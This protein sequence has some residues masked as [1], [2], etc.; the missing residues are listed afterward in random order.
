VSYKIFNP[1]KLYLSLQEQD[2]VELKTEGLFAGNTP[3]ENAGSS[4]QSA[5]TAE[6]EIAKAK[7]LAYRKQGGQKPSFKSVLFVGL[8]KGRATR[9]VEI[10]WW[11][12]L[13]STSHGQMT[14]R[15]F[16]EKCQF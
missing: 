4:S 9:E 8:G 14:I 2:L 1:E 5:L 11:P 16:I 7:S 15:M 10:I 12:E 13:Y 6:E 3:I